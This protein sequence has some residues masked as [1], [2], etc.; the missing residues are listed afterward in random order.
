MDLS[1][2]VGNGDLDYNS[3]DQARELIRRVDLMLS[4]LLS[5]SEE[6]VKRRALIE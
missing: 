3:R 5:I 2:R 1:M 4:K 6:G